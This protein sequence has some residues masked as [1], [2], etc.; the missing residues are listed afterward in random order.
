[1]VKLIL[2]EKLKPATI[3]P[4]EHTVATQ[5]GVINEK[6]FYGNLNFKFTPT[7][8]NIRSS[9][10]VTEALGVLRM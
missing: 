6:H 5:Q 9:Y 7:K 10:P 8:I 4:F 2:A 1:M 3:T